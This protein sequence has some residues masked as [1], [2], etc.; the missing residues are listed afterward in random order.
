VGKTSELKKVANGTHP[1]LDKK[2]SKQKELDKLAKG[3]HP[4]NKTYLSSLW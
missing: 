2:W 4:S 3:I 1:F